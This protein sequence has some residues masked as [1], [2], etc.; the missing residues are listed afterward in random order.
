M[1]RLAEIIYICENKTRFRSDIINGK[2]LTDLFIMVLNYE[3]IMICNFTLCDIHA[4]LIFKHVL[5]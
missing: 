2:I 4:K 3:S 5:M 1:F